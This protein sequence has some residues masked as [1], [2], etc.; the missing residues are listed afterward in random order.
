[1]AKAPPLH[2]REKRFTTGRGQYTLEARAT[3]VKLCL[4]LRV[5]SD[6][7]ACQ[8]AVEALSRSPPV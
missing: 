6:T 4:I 5:K 8:T 1:M 7:R 2:F 3:H